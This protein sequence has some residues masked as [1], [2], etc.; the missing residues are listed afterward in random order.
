MVSAPAVPKPKAPSSTRCEVIPHAFEFF[1]NPPTCDNCGRVHCLNHAG[2][3]LEEGI[4]KEKRLC[5]ICRAAYNKDGLAGLT[6]ARPIPLR[7]HGS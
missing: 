2:V 3:P 5:A 7:G 4:T 6:A 1:G